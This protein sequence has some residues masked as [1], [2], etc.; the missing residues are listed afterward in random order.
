MGENIISPQL[1]KGWIL[2]RLIEVISDNQ[3]GIVKSSSEQNKMGDGVGYIK[4]NN[5]TMDG[6]V[7]LDNLVY[8]FPQ[9]H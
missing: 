3:I 8:V 1:P 9:A 5:I 2:S 6:E 4:M 7:T